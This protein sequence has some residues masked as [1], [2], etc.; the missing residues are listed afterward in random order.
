MNQ[1]EL[2]QPVSE[3]T[4]MLCTSPFMTHLQSVQPQ[5]TLLSPPPPADSIHEISSSPACH[6]LQ[7]FHFRIQGPYSAAPRF[8]SEPEPTANTC[9]KCSG[10]FKYGAPSC[11]KRFNK[12]LLQSL[13]NALG[14]KDQS[15]LACN[16]PGLFVD[17]SLQEYDISVMVCCKPADVFNKLY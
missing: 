17:L 5:V 15:P 11:C 6:S 9:P 13:H 10:N 8:L 12:F 3:S 14:L 2:R 7:L 16:F 1:S 4:P